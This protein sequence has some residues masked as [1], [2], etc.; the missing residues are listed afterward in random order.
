VKAELADRRSD[1]VEQALR[2]FGDAMK[3]GQRHPL[4]PAAML[5]G[6]FAAG[7][8]DEDAAHGL[9]SFGMST[10]VFA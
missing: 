5:G 7:L 4:P 3:L 2:R 8:L 9:G 10:K 6:L 1:E